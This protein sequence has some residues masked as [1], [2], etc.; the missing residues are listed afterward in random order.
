LKNLH[1]VQEM[2]ILKKVTSNEQEHSEN[3][4]N[5][6]AVMKTNIKQMTKSERLNNKNMR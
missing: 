3:I 6:Y 1:I 5:M 4:Q 2:L